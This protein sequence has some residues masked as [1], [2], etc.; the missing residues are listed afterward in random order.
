MGLDLVKLMIRQG[1]A[2]SAGS[3]GLSSDSTEMQQITYDSLLAKGRDS[4]HGYAIE[5]RVYAENPTQDFRPCPG[6]LQYVSIPTE[7]WLRVETWVS[8]HFSL[9][10][11]APHF[12]YLLDLDGY[13]HHTFF[14][15]PPRQARCFWANSTR[16]HFEAA[17]GTKRVANSRTEKQHRVLES[18]LERRGVWTGQRNNNI[19]QY[20]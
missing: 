4:G 3:H 19:P 5:A 2:E 1:L 16:R 10:S 18:Y 11:G 6:I 12:I 8:G 9:L 20:L 7:D 15:S 17:P 14:R 13:Y